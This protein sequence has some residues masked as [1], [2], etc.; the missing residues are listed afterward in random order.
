MYIWF[1]QTDTQHILHITINTV[2]HNLI[3][4][5]EDNKEELIDALLAFAIL[6]ETE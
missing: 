2:Q 6:L 5:T 3:L 1:E 4:N